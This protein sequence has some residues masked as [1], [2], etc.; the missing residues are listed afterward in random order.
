MQSLVAKIYKMHQ[1]NISFRSYRR[2][3]LSENKWRASKDGIHADL[4]DFGKETSVPYAI[5]LDELLEFI[6]DVVDGLGC[7]T[8]VE[9][10]RQIVKMGTGADRQLMVFNET[11]DIKKVVDYMICETEKSVL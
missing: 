10:A 4:I 7:R 11:G 1:Q 5:L 3:L 8:E 6:D 2:L 9:Y